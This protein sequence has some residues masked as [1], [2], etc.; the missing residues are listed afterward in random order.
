MT[1]TPVLRR[2]VLWRWNDRATPDQ[3]LRAKEGLAYI[4]YASRVDA[5]DFGED[6]GLAGESNYSLALVRDHRDKASWDEYNHDPHHHR[7]GGFIDTITDEPRTARADYLYTGPASMPGRVRH[8]AL[9][10]WREGVDD[11]HK[12]DARRALAALRAE[13][14]VLYALE[15]ADDLGWATLGR[16]DLV[17]E[18]H[19]ADEEAAGAFLAHPAY[20]EADALLGAL[21]RTDRTAVIQ[22]RMRAG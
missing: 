6:L 18:A 5:V 2:A 9:Y 16:A 7:V 12:R 17:V 4:S 21:T 11:R 8:L 22:H 14:E 3:R 13:C 10:A 20:H 19:V 1:A 15:L